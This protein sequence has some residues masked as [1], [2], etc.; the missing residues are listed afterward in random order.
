[1]KPIKLYRYYIKI[2]K[3]GKE[4]FVKELKTDDWKDLCSFVDELIDKSSFQ[5][6]IKLNGGYAKNKATGLTSMLNIKGF[7]S[8][9]FIEKI[10]G[11]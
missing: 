1:M 6:V 5:I 9:E 2:R 4:G 3:R 8:R 7:K 10:M 11:M